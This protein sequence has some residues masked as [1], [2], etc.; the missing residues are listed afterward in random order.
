H[1]RRRERAAHTVNNERN[2]SPGHERPPG[3]RD[4]NA[5]RSTYLA[6]GRKER[7]RTP[8]EARPKESSI[9]RYAGQTRGPSKAV[10]KQISAT[11]P[12]AK[13]RRVLNRLVT[14]NIG[15]KSTRS[16]GLYKH[17]DNARP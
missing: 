12:V 9:S 7:V 17:T 4:E 15:R 14:N 13:P 2:V 10:V 8:A 3:R 1:N 6:S 5:A 11:A 16:V